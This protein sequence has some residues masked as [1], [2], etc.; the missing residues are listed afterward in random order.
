MDQLLYFSLNRKTLVGFHNYVKKNR[1]EYIY[2]FRLAQLPELGYSHVSEL[3]DFL[4][5]QKKL[6]HIKVIVDYISLTCLPKTDTIKEA[7][8]FIR[9]LIV[10]YPEVFFMF[11]ET[12]SSKFDFTDFLFQGGCKEVIKIFL[13]KAY[14]QF[15]A[16]REESLSL[17]QH[18]GK[19]DNIVEPESYNPFIVFSR[20]RNNL[21]DG[22]NLR[23]VTKRYIY[24]NIKVGKHN[25]SII[26]G[27]RANK[28]ALCVEEEDGQSRFNCYSLFANGFRALPVLSAEELKYFNDIQNTLKPAIITR[29]YDLQFDDI[30]QPMLQSEYNEIDWVRGYKYYDEEHK[31]ITLMGKQTDGEK[32]ERGLGKSNSYWDNFINSGTPVYFVTKGPESMLVELE[33]PKEE[34][35]RKKNEDNLIVQGIHKPVPGIYTSFQKLSTIHETASKVFNCFNRNW[36]LRREVA[37]RV[38][39][40]GFLKL[41]GDVKMEKEIIKHYKNIIDSHEQNSPL[42][43]RMKNNERPDDYVWLHQIYSI[44]TGREDHDHGVPLNVYD[45]VKEMVDRAKQYYEEKKYTRAAIIAWEAIEVMNGFHEA[46]TLKAYHIYALSDN[47]IAMNVLGGKDEELTED[48]QFRADRIRSDINRLLYRHK[49]NEER[50]KFAKNVLSQIFNDCRAFCKQK[51]HYGSEG[52]FISAIG[53]LNNSDP[54]WLLFFNIRRW[55]WD[56]LDGRKYK[57][58]LINNSHNT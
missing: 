51:E 2:S 50:R 28:L 17:I 23:Y 40:N 14:H 48:T 58:W 34:I 29:D 52:V 56:W 38:L 37:Y 36:L 25:F 12:I 41:K 13:F 22:S 24:D 11:D 33:K 27:S 32:T 49:E 44:K 43:Y 46:L 3:A 26:Q 4:N 39:Y 57:R 18:D 7:Q 8:D 15:R 20:S 31:W 30:K 1:F 9:R 6:S 42:K 10:Q 45:M 53:H 16:C 21:F 5:V 47:A 55:F 19:E 54:T 35:K